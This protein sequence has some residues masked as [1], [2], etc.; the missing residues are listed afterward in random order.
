[1]KTL[2]WNLIAL[3]AGLLIGGSVNMA[4]IA[5]GG[6]W[7][8]P[9]PGVNPS[10]AQ[11][12]A[13]HIHEYQYHQLLIPFLAHALGTLVGAS[14]AF[15]LGRRIRWTLAWIVGFAFLAGGIAAVQMIPAPL[16]FVVLDLG[17]AYLPMAWLATRLSESFAGGGE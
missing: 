17:V 1:M 14:V 11:S 10:D 5:L 2:V 8:P 7:V 13:A 4:I 3:V 9:P 15:I 16:W 12:I 6:H